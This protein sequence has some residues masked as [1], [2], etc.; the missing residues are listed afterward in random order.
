MLILFL[1]LAAERTIIVAQATSS[2]GMN[3]VDD[4]LLISNPSCRN[5]D[6]TC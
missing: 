4:I 5:I 3:I 6:R 2:S 1:V